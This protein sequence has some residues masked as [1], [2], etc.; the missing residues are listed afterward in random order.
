MSTYTVAVGLADRGRSVRDV[1]AA[2]SVAA[3]V[4]HAAVIAE[5]VE[6]DWRF[7]A[8]FVVAAAFQLA[9]AIPTLLRSSR[10]VDAVGAAM[11][12]AF[13]ATWL[14]SRTTGLPIGPHAWTP[15]ATGAA[16]VSASLLELVVVVGSLWL[17]RAH[18]RG[19]RHQGREK[20]A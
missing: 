19:T 2:A 10:A 7:G 13:I 12:A 3:G 9:W 6:E 5:H 8:F 16:D 14:A 4:V 15:E 20:T 1:I 18:G 11:N 17:L